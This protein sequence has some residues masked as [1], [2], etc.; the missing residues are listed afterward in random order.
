MLRSIK[1]TDDAFLPTRIAEVV[2]T[3]IGWATWCEAANKAG[4]WHIRA[5]QSHRTLGP[6]V[7]AAKRF[8]ATGKVG[9]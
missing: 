8:I 4:V 5:I 7:A 1:F 3:A 9:R 2:K 6:A